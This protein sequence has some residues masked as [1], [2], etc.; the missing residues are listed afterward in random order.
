[1]GHYVPVMS[2]VWL[3]YLTA[4]SLGLLI[5]IERE[6][7]KGQ[8][9]MREAA[10][11]RTFTVA[12]LLGCLSWQLGEAP[13]LIGA[14]LILGALTAMSYR[15]TAPRDP[16]LT[17]EI[18]LLVT[19]LLGALAQVHA[20]MAAG[21]GV[22]VAVLLSVRTR[23]HKFI[24]TTL[25][26]AELHDGL[27]L[28][29]AVL[30]ILPLLPD[31]TIDPLHTLNP[32][33]LWLIVVVLLSISAFGHIASRAL[34]PRTGLP[35]AGFVSGFVSSAAT[36]SA[37]GARAKAQPDLHQPAV[38]GAVLSTVATIV[39]LALLLSVTH[40]D[41][42]WH[43]APALSAGASMAIIYGLIFTRRASTSP[44]S[45]LE[46]QARPLSP[47]SALAFAAIIMAVSFGV[48]ALNHYLGSSGALAGAG[49]AGLADAH[50]ASA[51]L[52]NLSA[53]NALSLDMA[54]LGILTALTTN[55][56]T[57]IL[58]ARS[59]GSPRFAREVIPGLLLVLFACW[60]VAG[61]GGWL[62][63]G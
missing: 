54:G 50:A 51:S 29:G 52:A 44:A 8:G 63:L 45:G 13:L 37:L 57:K 31:Q 2:S 46:A 9:P 47:L 6:R 59:M 56:L 17:T 20:P 43:L 40:A 23:L 3:S 53:Q 26:D 4:L 11:V 42:L 41:L 15:Y 24:R 19:T 55:S 7:R 28:A 38:A 32:H 39:Q 5:G 58:L 10:G 62:K 35:L 34:G 48:A 49:L 36:I 14:L 33:T 21:L 22:A 61:A 25:T 12:A 18:A 1:M 60:L 16:G 30:V 27:L